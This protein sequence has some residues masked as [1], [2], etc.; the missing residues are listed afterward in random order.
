MSR[1]VS[2]S[3]AKKETNTHKNQHSLSSRDAML[4]K[5]TL[6]CLKENNRSR[7]SRIQENEGPIQRLKKKKVSW[8]HVCVTIYLSVN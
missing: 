8:N 6:S 5:T 7:A 1:E 4:A 2:Y 3:V